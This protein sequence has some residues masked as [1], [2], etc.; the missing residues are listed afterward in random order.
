MLVRASFHRRKIKKVMKSFTPTNSQFNDFLLFQ[1]DLACCSN[2]IVYVCKSQSFLEKQKNGRSHELSY[3]FMNVGFAT[4]LLL[5]QV[6]DQSKNILLRAMRQLSL[7]WIS[8]LDLHH[9]II[10]AWPFPTVFSRTC[11]LEL[12]FWCFMEFQ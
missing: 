3:F 7:T 11:E 1:Q 12:L 4:H 2:E 9:E 6:M 5:A 10:T 8:M